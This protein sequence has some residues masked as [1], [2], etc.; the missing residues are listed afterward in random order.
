MRESLSG[1][2]EVRA[3]SGSAIR[4]VQECDRATVPFRRGRVE[5][6]ELQRVNHCGT[7]VGLDASDTCCRLVPD[8]GQRKRLSGGE[9]GVRL[10][11]AAESRMALGAK[12]IQVA[13]RRGARSLAS[14]V[15]EFI[16]G[17]I[18]C[19]KGLLGFVAIHERVVKR[20]RGGRDREGR[21]TGALLEEPNR[22]GHLIRGPRRAKVRIREL[23]FSLFQGAGEAVDFGC[24][25]KATF[26]PPLRSEQEEA[27]GSGRSNP[28]GAPQQPVRLGLTVHERQQHLSQRLHQERLGFDGRT[29]GFEQRESLLV[30][31]QVAQDGQLRHYESGVVRVVG[32]KGF[33]RGEGLH[34]M[35]IVAGQCQRTGFGQPMMR[36]LRLKQ[37]ERR[38]GRCAIVGEQGPLCFEEQ[39]V[40]L[41]IRQM[42][43][44]KSR[45]LGSGNQC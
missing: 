25:F 21:A 38:L 28:H 7:Q 9:I 4:F 35:R 42:E 23:V 8:C 19:G 18:Q 3:G 45:R 31:V 30:S 37:R 2:A 34:G 14:A 5:L 22:F 15:R 11:A 24:V 10:R 13:E 1:L 43:A 44:L 20:P 41:G 32:E 36:K 12:E 27:G 40:S 29:L 39:I 17:L 6:Q 33:E 26:F 16:D